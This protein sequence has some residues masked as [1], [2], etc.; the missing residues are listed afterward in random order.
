M[1]NICCHLRILSTGNTKTLNKTLE[2]SSNI[3]IYDI[4]YP[5]ISAPN[6][7]EGFS[8]S[9]QYLFHLVYEG[10]KQRYG[11]VN[12]NVKK[13]LDFELLAICDSGYADYFL[14]V[15]D[16]LAIARATG[17]FISYGVGASSGSIINYCLRITEIDPI[18]YDLLFERFFGNPEKNNIPYIIIYMVIKEKN[19]HEMFKYISKKYGDIIQYSFSD[20]N[21]YGFVAMVQEELRA[22]YILQKTIDIIRMIRD[23]HI[24]INNISFEDKSAY[25]LFCKCETSDIYGFDMKDMK[26]YLRKLPPT[27]IEHLAVLYSIEIMQSAYIKP[28]CYKKLGLEH[29]LKDSFGIIAFQEQ[30][31]TISCEMAGFSP[32][33]SDD[34]RIA[35]GK[36][37]VNRLT[38]FR[39]QFIEG[40]KTNGYDEEM[41]LK[42]W[43]SI[44]DCE[45]CC[46][47]KSHAIYKALIAYQMAWLKLYYPPEFRMALALCKY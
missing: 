7:P 4:G 3:A 10:A 6:I 32:W 33:Q 5:L 42:L 30:I 11:N 28:N 35:L 31:M 46:F 1:K 2:I 17:A 14:V 23:E 43:L 12:E 20:V 27:S 15:S 9:E 38:E 13:R 41:V 26:K 16:I 36:N 44:K 19:K 18:R 47:N 37:D 34:F 22:L 25:Q 39:K 29:F 24:D 8:T 40:C 21:N 45:S